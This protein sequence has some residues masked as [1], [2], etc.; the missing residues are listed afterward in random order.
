MICL[1]TAH[2]AKFGQAIKDATGRDT[3]RHPAI[4]ALKSLPTR[5]ELLPSSV[6]TMR[7]YIASKVGAK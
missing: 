4:E 3:A 7:E 6:E 1:A 5:C 2:P